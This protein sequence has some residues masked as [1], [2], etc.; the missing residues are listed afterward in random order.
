[1]HTIFFTKNIVF[2]KQPSLNYTFKQL[3]FFK[4]FVAIRAVIHF[5]SKSATAQKQFV[6]H[7]A[8]FLI[9]EQ[10]QLF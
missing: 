9:F 7:M 1:M 4:T 3:Q 6:I 5:W 10:L 8:W 2:P